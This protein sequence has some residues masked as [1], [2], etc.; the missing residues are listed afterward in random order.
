LR[1]AL[2]GPGHIGQRHA[3][4]YAKMPDVRVTAV[5][6]TET[7]KAEPLALQAGARPFDSLDEAL[8]SVDVDVVD[9][10]TPTP[11]HKA[12]V[13]AAATA[14]KHVICEKPLARSI[15]DAE[16]MVDAC[17][18]RGLTLMVGH[19]LRFFPQYEAA[20]SLIQSGAIGAPVIARTFRGN[21][22]PHGW[23]NWYADPTDSGGL[24]LDMVLHD[25]DW[26]RW[27][28]GE[29]ER[30][31]AR[32][33]V[34]DVSKGRDYAL[35]TVRHRSGV[36]AHVEGTWSHT[37]PFNM[38]LEVAGDAGLIDYDVSQ[39]RPVRFTPRQTVSGGE[40]KVPVPES[41]LAE[42]PYFL[43]LRHFVDVIRGEAEPRITPD[44]ALA[45]MRIALAA[46]DSIE[47]GNA[48][49]L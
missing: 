41:P 48:I 7:P 39:A 36:L 6:A 31:Y 20:R 40:K 25:F 22:F 5:V 14:G 35:V 27:T 32:G 45:A 49:S 28:F 26:L 17:R 8:S 30:V 1:I 10:C 37:T 46:L 42:D 2:V 44:D 47:T 38:K 21:G 18:S 29:V 33:L 15:A 23:H 13:L 43:E 16:E 24:L 34:R 12:G 11:L 3:A 9:L 19:V 4:Q